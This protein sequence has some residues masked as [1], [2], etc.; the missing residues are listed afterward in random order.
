M[1][2]TDRLDEVN[3]VF[4]GHLLTS[5]TFADLVP[6]LSILSAAEKTRDALFLLSRAYKVFCSAFYLCISTTIYMAV[7]CVLKQIFL[8]VEVKDLSQSTTP[9]QAGGVCTRAWLVEKC[10]LL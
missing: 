2:I 3:P 4:I 6:A 1:S 9:R 7:R 8:L 5:S 10:W